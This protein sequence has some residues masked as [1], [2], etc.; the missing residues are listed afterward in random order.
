[1]TRIVVGFLAILLASGPSARAQALWVGRGSTPQGDYLRGV[2][3]AAF[4]LGVLEVDAAQA[5]AINTATAIQWNEYVTMYFARENA[6]KALFRQA[7]HE[8]RERDWKA[9]R[10]RIK[11]SPEERELMNGEALNALLGQLNDPRIHESSYRSVRV[12]LPSDIVRHI[13]F[14]IDEEAAEFSMLRLIPRGKGKWPVAFQDPRFDYDRRVYEQAVDAALEQQLS[15]K[16]TL[17][18]IVRVKEAIEGLSRALDASTLPDKELYL[19]ART[20][21]KVLR[22]QAKLLDSDKVERVVGEI[23]GFAGT[24]VNDLREFMQR[25]KLR[26]GATADDEERRLYPTLYEA[27]LTQKLLVEDAINP[28]K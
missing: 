5:N 18:A 6:E 2:G 3:A 17:D 25:H 4:G 27:L 16:M 13:P 12:P 14:R 11:T 20:R 9:I 21:I 15:G 8:K 7:Q 26:F 23:D 28:G 19:R 24:T 10:E 1:M 22:E